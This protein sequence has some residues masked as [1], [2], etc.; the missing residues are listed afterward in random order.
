M[1]K[2]AVVLMA[3]AMTLALGSMGVSAEE[4]SEGVMTYAYDLCGV[5]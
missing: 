4:K 5:C 3:A 2:T 1:K